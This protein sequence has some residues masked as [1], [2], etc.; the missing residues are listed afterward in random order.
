MYFSFVFFS[1]QT[2]KCGI[3]RRSTGRYQQHGKDKLFHQAADGAGEGVPLQQVLDPGP[4]DRDRGGPAAE[5]DAG[6]DLVPEPE[7]EAE[8]A[9]EGGADPAGPD[10]DG[11]EHESHVTE[12]Y[13]L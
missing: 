13:R 9:D 12:Q 4:E 10:T 2:R 6:Q 3:F 1:S 8:E 7:D 11:R 5:R